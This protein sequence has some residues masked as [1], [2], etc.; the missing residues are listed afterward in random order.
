MSCMLKRKKI[1]PAYVSK[2]NSN[3]ENKIL[4]DDSKWTSTALS[5]NKE[6]SVLLRRITSKHHGGLFCRNCL[7]SFTKENKCKSHKKG[8]ENTKFCNFIF[9]SEDNQT[10]EFNHYQK[11]DKSFIQ[12][13]NV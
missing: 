3:C 9:P 5:C 7:H 12:I 10:L 2:H 6:L 8:C 11:S 4:L 13:L 1:Y